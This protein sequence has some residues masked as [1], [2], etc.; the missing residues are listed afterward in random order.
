MTGFSKALDISINIEQGMPVFPGDPP[1]QHRSVCSF[2][3]GDPASVSAF[4]I[5]A[6]TGT[7]LDLPSHFFA[8]QPTLETLPPEN[9]IVPALLIDNGKDSIVGPEAITASGACAGEALLIRTTNSSSGVLTDTEFRRD[10]VYLAPEAAE[11]CVQMSLA[12]VGIDCFCVD[13]FDNTEYPSHKILLGA[14]IF[15][16][17]GIDLSRAEQGRY[18]LAALPLKISGAEASPVRA[19]LLQ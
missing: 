1:F 19:V 4:D 14:G 7:H 18:T 3:Q 17:E 6:H 9:F 13:N 2:D 15:I 11:A 10:Y 12:L 16:L 8:G 5:C